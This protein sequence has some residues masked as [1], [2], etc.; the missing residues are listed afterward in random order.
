MVAELLRV[1]LYAGYVSSYFLNRCSQFRLTAPSYEDVR[2]FFHKLL[3]R[4]KANAAIATSNEC[5]FSFDLVQAFPPSQQS[6]A[7]CED[8]S[9]EGAPRNQVTQSISL[10]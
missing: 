8:D 2:A 4:R 6:L 10:V 7:D 9:A 5:H 3:C 1:S